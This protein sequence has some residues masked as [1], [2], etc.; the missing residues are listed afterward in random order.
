MI[1]STMLGRCLPQTWK[2]PLSTRCKPVFTFLIASL[3][4]L[5]AA[6]AQ[7]TTVCGY[8]V[9]TAV[10]YSNGQTTFTWTVTNTNPGNGDNGTYQDLSHFSQKFNPCVNANDH[11][12][13]GDFVDKDPSQNCLS[14]PFLKF[15]EGTKGSTPTV[16]TAVFNGFYTTC[17]VDA[18]FKSGSAQPCCTGQIYGV[19]CCDFKVTCP[20]VKDL[21]EYNCKKTSSIPAIPTT[22][23][24]AKAAPYNIY[25]GDNSC[26]TVRVYGSDD[27]Q[28]EVCSKSDQVIT[29]TIMIYDDLNNNSQKDSGEPFAECKF[30]YKVKADTEAPKFECK[31]DKHIDCKDDVKFDEPTVTDNCDANPNVTHGDKRTDGTCGYSIT[32]TWTATDACNNTSTCSQTIYV[33]DKTAPVLTC[34]PN[35]TIKC[36]DPVKFDEPG[37]YDNCDPDPK[38]EVVGEDKVTPGSCPQNYTITRTWRAVDKC[39]NPCATTCSQTITVVDDKAPVI[40]CKP[41]K[42]LDCKDCKN[43]VTF[44]VP[45]AT[46]NCDPAPTIVKACEDV[47]TPGNC[48][49]SYSIKRT[50]YAVDACGNKSEWHSQTIY[51]QDKTAPVITCKPNKIIQCSQTPVFD[52]P[53]ATDNCDPE[54]KIVKAGEDV[55]TPGNCPQNYS[56]KRSW[57]SVDACGNKSEWCSQTITVVDNQAPVITCKPN[58]YVDC[59]DCKSGVTFDE[60]T[61]TDNCD[62]NPKVYKACEDVKTPGNCPQ[63]YSIK[64]SWYAVDACGNKSAWCSQTVYVQDKTAPVIYCPQDVTIECGGSTDPSYCKKATATDNCDPNPIITFTDYKVNQS[65]GYKI[66]RT[67]RATDKCGNYKECKQ[68]ITVPCCNYCTYTQGFYSNKNGLALLPS[69]LTT[70]ITIGRTG[71]SVTIPANTTMVKSAAKLNSILPGGTS[72][73]VLKAGDCNI[74]NACLSQY[75][76]STG[77][78]N[79]ILLSQTITLTLNTRLKGGILLAFPIQSGYLTTSSGSCTKINSN[80]V[81]YLTANRTKKATVADLLNLANDVLGGTKTAGVGGVPSLSDIN[82]AVDAIN[83]AFDGC[84]TFTGYK[85]SCPITS[86]TA[87]SKAEGTVEEVANLSVVS[88]H[89]SPN[90]YTDRVKFVINSTISGRGSLDLYNLLGQ[91]VGTV[92]QGYITAGKGQTIEYTVPALHRTTLVYRLQVGDKQATGKLINPNGQ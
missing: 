44:D 80:V 81:N 13:G 66:V 63:S 46:D 72:A 83:N 25:I 49:Q 15:D 32:R 12:S 82:A 42:Y 33:E 10:S 51:V 18:V 60:P 23:S 85:A 77:R 31:S 64:R 57:Y 19:C 52:L 67:W 68:T 35:K 8:K 62:P 55:K 61:A 17:L 36:T 76:T 45:T 86:I 54:P 5:S 34:K 58:K 30:T 71:H 9:T 40:T 43:G 73:K 2:R 27:K 7:T 24:A 92:F 14:G 11:V 65:C 16:Y 89:A 87:V 53:T 84:R 26:G 75:L 29:R 59:K 3:T 88:V 79:N 6:V 39:G 90:P 4:L 74:M 1:E 20:D 78:I 50:W 69:L 91:K 56:I 38:V 37:V 41:D 70:P 47:K 21:G 28:P 48:P 22:V